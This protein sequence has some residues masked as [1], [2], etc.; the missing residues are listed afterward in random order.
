[1]TPDIHLS[2][3]PENQLR[4]WQLL[5]QETE[6]LHRHQLYLAG[7]TALAL[8]L[9]H[10]RSYDFDFFTQAEKI[11]ESIHT[12]IQQKDLGVIRDED[13]NTVHCDIHSVKASFIGAYKYPTIAPLITYNNFYIAS[14]EDIA[15]M[16]FLAITHRATIRDYIDIA[17]ILQTHSLATLLNLSKKKYGQSFNPFIIVKSLVSFDDLDQEMPEMIDTSLIDSWKTIITHAV[18]KLAED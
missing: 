1:M 2:I 11:G 14:I 4:I 15:L 13:Q 10:R 18:Q 3:L 16:K 9:G 5:L 12:W 8:Q 7:G 6:E 17:A